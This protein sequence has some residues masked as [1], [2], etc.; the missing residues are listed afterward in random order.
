[1]QFTPASE[2]LPLQLPLPLYAKIAVGEFTQPATG[3]HFTLYAGADEKI[4]TE[5]KKKS[6][7]ES[8]AELD[9]ATSDRKRFGEGSYEDWYKKERTPFSL[10]HTSTGALAAFAWYGPKPL[11]R[12]SLKHLSEEELAIEGSQEKSE[13][14]T[15]VYRSY[16][17]FRGTGIMKDFVKTTMD[18]YKKSV[19]DI[20]LWAGIQETNPSSV[21]LAKKLGFVEHSRDGHA[22]FMIE[23]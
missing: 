16:P 18:I 8:D 19:P 1:M 20:K 14:H 10:I 17:P 22:I 4:V 5:L 23:A 7:D 11:G 3:E 6:L 2:T 15:I 9:Q 13:W 21:A 12:K